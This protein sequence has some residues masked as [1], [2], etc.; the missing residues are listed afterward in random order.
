MKRRFNV[1]SAEF[2]RADRIN[3][4]AGGWWFDGNVYR[5]KQDHTPQKYLKLGFNVITA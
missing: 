4:E 1:I 3:Q 2:D 5:R